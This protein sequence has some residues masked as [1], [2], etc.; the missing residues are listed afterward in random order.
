MF[1]KSHKGINKVQE[2]A[3]GEGGESEGGERRGEHKGGEGRGEHEGGEGRGEHEGG[4]RR[5][6]HEGGEGR[7]IYSGGSRG[8]SVGS[9]DPP[10]LLKRCL[11]SIASARKHST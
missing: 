6:E 7:G 4:E 1:Q 3:K 5:G 11:R 9:M 8:G 10:P 2:R